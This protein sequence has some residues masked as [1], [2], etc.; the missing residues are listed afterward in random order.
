MM[1]AVLLTFAKIW[2]QPKYPST[3]EW[4]EDVICVCMCV[5]I[6]TYITSSIH[7]YIHVHTHMP[8]YIMEYYSA[9]KK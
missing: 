3:D 8:L 4:V 1:I 7:V 6:H 9:M 5:Y 2:K